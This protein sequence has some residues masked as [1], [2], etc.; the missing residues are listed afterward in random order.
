[1][2]AAKNG[3]FHTAECL[4]FAGSNRYYEEVRALLSFIGPDHRRNR[5][6]REAENEEPHFALC[7][8]FHRRHPA[9][10]EREAGLVRSEHSARLKR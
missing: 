1:M 4:A 8:N 9:T 5:R 3:Q 10:G 6:K 2:I 7:Y